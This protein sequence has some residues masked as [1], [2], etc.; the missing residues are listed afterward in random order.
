M[1]NKKA[2]LKIY[3]IIYILVRKILA[4]ITSNTISETI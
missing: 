4:Q 2:V 3:M 1:K